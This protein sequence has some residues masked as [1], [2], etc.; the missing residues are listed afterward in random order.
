MKKLAAEIFGREKLTDLVINEVLGRFIGFMVGMLTAKFFSHEV[1]ERKGI[2]NL[3]GI[4]K[5]KK[6]IVNTTPEWLQWII[7]A[8]VGYITPEL[9]NYFFRHKLYLDVGWFCR[10]TYADLTGRP[11]KKPQKEE[12]IKIE[13]Q[14][15]A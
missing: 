1:Y 3:F 9:V 13:F 11:Y 6:V 12:L 15:K 2:K 8:L 10:Q 7:C 4:F 5:R 14:K